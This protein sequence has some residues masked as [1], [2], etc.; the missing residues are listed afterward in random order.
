LPRRR[1]GRGSCSAVDVA[2]LRSRTGWGT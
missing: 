1:S 2:R